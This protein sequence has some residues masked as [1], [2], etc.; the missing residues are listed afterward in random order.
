[1]S[2]LLDV[3]TTAAENTVLTDVL[4][5][6]AK[7]KIL[8]ALLGESD[9]DLNATEI[10]RLAGIDRTTFY[11]HVEDLLAYGMIEKTRTVGNSQMY[12]IN[13]ENPAAEDLARMEWHLLDQIEKHQDEE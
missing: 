6:H 4:G 1:M 5:P 2:S 9:R 3:D 12:R 8:T 11:E 10:A 7:V 13:R